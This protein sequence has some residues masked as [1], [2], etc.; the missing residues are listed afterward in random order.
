[1]Q[2]VDEDDGVLVLHQL[3]HDCFQALFELAAV[4]GAGHN[5]AQVEREHLLFSQEA[6][7]LTIG[8]LLRKTLDDG[9]LADT[10]LP[11]QNGVVLGAPAENLDDA[12]DLEVATDKRIQCA[13]LGRLGE[14]AR[15]LSEHGL[16]LLLTALLG[17]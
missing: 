1:M 4:L 6:R 7:N 2:L 14:V 11:D 9:S 17:S 3:L 15:K 12:L 10:R 13:V 5:Q 16:L 8:D